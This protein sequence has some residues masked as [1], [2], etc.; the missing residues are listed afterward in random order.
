MT[1]LL[2]V[3]AAFG[4]PIAL[5]RGESPTAWASALQ[6]AGLE[7]GNPG[8]G[9]GVR[10]VV[11][12]GGWELLVR[13]EHGE[14]RRITVPVPRTDA[15]REEVAAL[16]A[17]LLH[18]APEISSLPLPSLP[19]L[20]PP[21]PPSTATS[22]ST[23]SSTSTSTV[24]STPP[25]LPYEP[26]PALPY[27]A[28]LIVS[29]PAVTFD[30]RVPIASA[31]ARFFAGGGLGLR[32]RSEVGPT[33]VVSGWAGW[34]PFGLPVRVGGGLELAPF[35]AALNQLPDDDGAR[36][37]SAYDGKVLAA[38]SPGLLEL[39]GTFGL[40]ARLFSDPTAAP[41]PAALIPTAGALAAWRSRIVPIRLAATGEYDLAGTDLFYPEDTP[42]GR[43]P[44]FSLGLSFSIW[45]GDGSLSGDR[46][47]AGGSA[48]R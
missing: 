41:P 11:L 44:R 36:R 6:R 47:T 33:P 48:A 28:Q 22:T 20:P 3:A 38:W 46:S 42:A 19:P 17:S 32:V 4:A 45:G 2:L 27:E 39:G 12:S 1:W 35:P 26:P 34:I 43:L 18:P 8:S 15:E 13:D 10:V 24:T 31:S 5:P 9:E 21:T 40:S 16:A 25:A 29:V 23:V 37:M 7:P 14:E 30:A